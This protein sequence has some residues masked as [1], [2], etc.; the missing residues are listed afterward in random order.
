LLN[1]FEIAFQKLK[2]DKH[3]HRYHE[4]Y[5]EMLGESSVKSLLEI[6]VAFG[7]S[8]KAWKMIW[9]SALIEGIDLHRMY[10]LTLENDFKIYNFDSIDIDK[11]KTITKTYDIIVDDGDH[12]WKTQLL[13]FNNYHD[14]ANKFYVI[15]DV[16]GIRS[17]EKLKKYLPVDFDKNVTIFT[18]QGHKRNF[19]VDEITERDSYRILFIDMR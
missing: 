8:I 9:P 19:T 16:K 2:C 10:D 3:Y 1:K 15:E 12:N 6:G 4:C 13:T 14:K 7:A 18:S 11:A 17:L 5:Y